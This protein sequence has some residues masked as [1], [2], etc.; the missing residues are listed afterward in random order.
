MTIILTTAE[1]ERV[2]GYKTP[3]HQ[4]EL[5]TIWKADTPCQIFLTPNSCRAPSA[6][7]RPNGSTPLGMTKPAKETTVQAG[8]NALAAMFR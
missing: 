4:V 1:L 3:K 7:R 2:T 5:H 8:L 6:P